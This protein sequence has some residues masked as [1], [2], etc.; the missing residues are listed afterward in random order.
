VPVCAVN[1]RSRLP[2]ITLTYACL[3]KSLPGQ[4]CTAAVNTMMVP[5]CELLCCAVLCA[6]AFCTSTHVLGT[7]AF[8]RPKIG[9]QDNPESG[10]YAQFWAYGFNRAQMR[11]FGLAAFRLNPNPIPAAQLMSRTSI[12]RNENGA[13]RQDALRVNGA[14]VR[15]R[16]Q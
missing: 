7:G 13:P 12:I 1:M 8:L 16:C 4:V 14:A 2:H 9:T 3:P 5:C 6:G 10:S 15:P 11:G